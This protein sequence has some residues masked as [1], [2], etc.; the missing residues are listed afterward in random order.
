MSCNNV[1]ILNFNH[2]IVEVGPDNKI[3]ITDQIKCNS[4]TIP[5][6]V[7]NILQI[8]SPG[9]QG[10]AGA[11]GASVNTGSFVTTSSFN[12]Y[13][14]SST[15]QFAGT[16]SFALTASYVNPLR[17]NVIITGSL[18][19][20]GSS[21]FTNIGP[22]ILS[23]S[24]TSTGGFTGSFSG[25]FTGNGTNLTNLPSQVQGNTGEIQFNNGGVFN[26]VPTLTYDGS[27]V[28]VTNIK[29]TGVFAELVT[30]TTVGNTSPADPDRSKDLTITQSGTY[31]LTVFSTVDPGYIFFPDPATYTGQKIRIQNRDSGDININPDANRPIDINDNRVPKIQ[32]LS[33][34][35]FISTG[36]YWYEI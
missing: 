27:L 14:G 18:I 31:I 24:V 2:N 12:A 19:V 10:P 8:N 17:Q 6:P 22:T 15:S 20:S 3:V 29:A 28:T 16:S 32:S 11:A 36:T 33:T 5:Q 30:V 23:G 26:G 13:T 21:T 1:Q 4:I 25:S 35:T 7:T 9:P 34:R